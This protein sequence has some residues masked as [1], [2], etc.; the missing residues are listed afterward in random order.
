MRSRSRVFGLCKKGKRLRTG[1]CSSAGEG[2][3]SEGAGGIKSRF[4]ACCR[5][6]CRFAG[7]GVV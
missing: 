6:I 4:N 3:A 7:R 5:S 1:A 2:I